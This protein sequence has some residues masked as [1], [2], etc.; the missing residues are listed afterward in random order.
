MIFRHLGEPK[1]SVF[2][3][4]SALLENSAPSVMIE[5]R[6]CATPLSL[7]L[8]FVKLW[9]NRICGCVTK[10]FIL[11][12]EKTHL[13]SFAGICRACANLQRLYIIPLIFEDVKEF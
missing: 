10:D 11:H 9:R 6:N 8:V 3:V 5:S 13:R 7:H 1:K 12:R 4:W 2:V